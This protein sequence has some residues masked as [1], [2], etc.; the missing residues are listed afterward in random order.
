VGPGGPGRGRRRGVADPAGTA[1]PAAALPAP[2]PRY[3]TGGRGAAAGRVP[4]HAGGAAAAPAPLVGAAQERPMDSQN[5]KTSEGITTSPSQPPSAP[6]PTR[7][8]TLGDFF[9][10]PM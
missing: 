10:N 8:P 2:A 9:R 6:E 5:S 7:P 1:R 3:N 4:A